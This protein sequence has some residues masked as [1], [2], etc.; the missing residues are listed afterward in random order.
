MPVA[1]LQRILVVCSR[2][3][4]QLNR[5]SHPS[6]QSLGTRDSTDNRMFS[7]MSTLCDTGYLAA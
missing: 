7:T 3:S 4:F 2:V 5:A 6:T 1:C